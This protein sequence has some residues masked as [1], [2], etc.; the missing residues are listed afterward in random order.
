METRYL[1]PETDLRLHFP[2][3]ARLFPPRDDLLYAPRDGKH[4]LVLDERDVDYVPCDTALDRQV[5]LL[6]FEE[7]GECMAYAAELVQRVRWSRRD[8]DEGGAGVPV[9][10]VVPPTRTPGAVRTFEESLEPPRNP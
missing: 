10:S 9:T 4:F 3:R 6:E 1:P 8:D 7:F 5:V 2:Q